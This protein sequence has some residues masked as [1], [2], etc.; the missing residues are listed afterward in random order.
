M[1]KSKRAKSWKS[2]LNLVEQE[3]YKSV[4]QG[5]KR[6]L[7]HSEEF[8]IMKIVLDKFLW[9]GT[10]LFGF[11][12]YQVIASD[13]NNGLW[14]ILAGVLVMIVFAWFVVKEFERLR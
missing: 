10:G 12:L 1:K 9:L 5:S 14:F 7:S 13:F 8:E 6:H 2:E 3:V 11:G 4:G